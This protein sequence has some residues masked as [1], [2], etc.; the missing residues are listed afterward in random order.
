MTLRRDPVGSESKARPEAFR[1]FMAFLLI[2]FTL[3]LNYVGD[4]LQQVK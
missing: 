3:Y 2:S 4:F 1:Q